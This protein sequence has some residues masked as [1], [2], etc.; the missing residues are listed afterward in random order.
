MSGQIQ[1]SQTVLLGI[2]NEPIKK[3]LQKHLYHY[4]VREI[5]LIYTFSLQSIQQLF[6]I[7]MQT[8]LVCFKFISQHAAT[9]LMR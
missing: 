2:I 1:F 5:I 4:E 8:H 7:G 9:L 3:D 6:L